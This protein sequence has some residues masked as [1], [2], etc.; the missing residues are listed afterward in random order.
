MS[1]KVEVKYDI[2][3]EY[4][5]KKFELIAGENLYLIEKSNQHW[6]LCFR[7]DQ[8]LTFFVPASYVK[9]LLVPVNKRAVP[10]RPPPPPPS[11]SKYYNNNITS[12]LVDK[13]QSPPEIKQRNHDS[14]PSKNQKVSFN[15][16]R[17]SESESA[18]D[19]INDLDECLNREEELMRNLELTE[20]KSKNKKQKNAETTDL[21]TTLTTTISTTKESSSLSRLSTSNNDLKTSKQE[22]FK[23][24]SFLFFNFF[25]I[26]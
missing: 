13:Q 25:L 21:A 2:S 6:W 15:H 4:D 8:N 16:E 9:E 24:K 1:R 18:E 3:Y 22:L 11:K 7:L 20:D 12:E 19:I 26:F 10:P 14:S 23:V 17:L 5:E